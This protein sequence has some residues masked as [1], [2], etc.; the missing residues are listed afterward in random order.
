[1]A[2]PLLVRNKGYSGRPFHPGPAGLSLSHA[3]GDM[4]SWCSDEGSPFSAGRWS[5]PPSRRE[6]G[7]LPGF[8]SKILCSTNMDFAED[9]VSFSLRSTS[10]NRSGG[11]SFRRFSLDIEGNP[12]MERSFAIEEPMGGSQVRKLGHVRVGRR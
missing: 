6:G 2:R 10:R 8:S 1:M 3:Q 5:P 12:D 11:G 4:R 9:S 7:A